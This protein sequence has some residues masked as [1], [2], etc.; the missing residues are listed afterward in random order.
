ME[1]RRSRSNDRRRR[2][3]SR[4]RRR[5]RSPGRHR[6]RSR[7]RRSR[8]WSKTPRYPSP[9]KSNPFGSGSIS[10]SP[11]QEEWHI[12]KILDVRKVHERENSREEKREKWKRDHVDRKRESKRDGKEDKHGSFQRLESRKEE[13]IVE[14]SE[15]RR[16]NSLEQRNDK[17]SES[18]LKVERRYSG[19]R[20]PSP[21]EP[22]SA[23]PAADVTSYFSQKIGTFQEKCGSVQKQPYPPLP[24]T[25]RSTGAPK[26]PRIQPRPPKLEADLASSSKVR[27]RSCYPRVVRLQNC[28]KHRW[29][30]PQISG[31]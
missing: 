11:R 15:K 31:Q 25:A 21:L 26:D 13:E 2:S 20:P 23:S 17:R 16:S 30:S 4:E 18:I 9:P 14:I 19:E 28:R 8:S 3:R 7:D 12:K 5:S 22:P 27:K 24:P 10:P 6:S 1:R 29:S